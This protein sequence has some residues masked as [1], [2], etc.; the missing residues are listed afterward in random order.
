MGIHLK[1]FGRFTRFIEIL[2]KADVGGS[3]INL[4]FEDYGLINKVF[5]SNKNLISAT[6]WLISKY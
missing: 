3:L 5:N 1:Q 4:A 2:N 6:L